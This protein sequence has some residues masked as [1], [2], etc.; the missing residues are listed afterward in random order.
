M[1]DGV[2][3]LTVKLPWGSDL[4]SVRTSCGAGWQVLATGAGGQSGDSV[5]VYEFPDRSAIQVSA[6]LDFAG[7]VTA[8][9]T[10]ARGDTAIAIARNRETG[11]YEA[12]RLA[13]ACNR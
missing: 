4:A 9:W 6:A 8:L 3:D 5:R 13:M 7:D 12:V 11:D 2:S 1:V 10:E